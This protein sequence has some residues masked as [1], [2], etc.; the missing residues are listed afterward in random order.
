MC[1]LL[2]P[3][4]REAHVEY[5]L[6]I[7]ARHFHRL[8]HL[9]QH[10]FAHQTPVPEH[11]HCGTIPLEQ[12]A[13]LTHLHQSR[14]GHVHQAVDFIFAPLEVFDAESVDGDVFDAA[15]VTHFQNSRKSF[16]SHIVAFHGFDLVAPRPAPVAIHNE[17]DVLRDWSASQ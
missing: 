12:F 3:S 1:D 2:A 15:L 10:I 11:A 9:L 16:K 7:L 14:L 6:I 17:G 13:V 4:I 8:I 5:C